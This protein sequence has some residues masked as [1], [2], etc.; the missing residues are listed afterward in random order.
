MKTV[1]H[2][3][4]C[5]SDSIAGLVNAFWFPMYA[6]PSD[7]KWQTQSEI[8]EKRMCSKCEKEWEDGTKF[9]VDHSETTPKTRRKKGK[10]E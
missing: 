10:I 5:G 1:E 7:I 2:C 6:E 9:T 8:S 4:Y 3:P